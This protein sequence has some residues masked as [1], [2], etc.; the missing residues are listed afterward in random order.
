MRSPT[1]RPRRDALLSV[2]VE[3]ALIS[4]LDAEAERQ[5]R[6]RSTMVRALLLDRLAAPV[7]PWPVVL[8]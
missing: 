5:G 7:T 4:R 2:R 6:D 8:G 1:T 3:P